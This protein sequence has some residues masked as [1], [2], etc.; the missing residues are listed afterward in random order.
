MRPAELIVISI[1]AGDGEELLFRGWLLHWF[2]D[3][4]VGVA[5]GPTVL[6]IALIRI[7]KSIGVVREDT[8]SQNSVD[9]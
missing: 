9:K 2:A 3:G 4:L 1:C 5:T 7:G 8:N 6:G